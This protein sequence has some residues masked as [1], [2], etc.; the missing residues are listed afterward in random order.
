[1]L[2]YCTNI[3]KFRMDK[4]MSQQELADLAGYKSRSSI[5][6][7]EKGITMLSFRQ[8]RKI[9][10]IL[11]VELKDLIPEYEALKP[12]DPARTVEQ[13]KESLEKHREKQEEIFQDL[14]SRTDEVGIA[15]RRL[16]VAVLKEE[17]YKAMSQVDKDF[18]ISYRR[19]N[20]NNKQ[21]I[22]N[23]M[24]TMILQQNAPSDEGES[25]P[26]TQKG[27]PSLQQCLDVQK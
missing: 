11:G 19:L 17:R 10:E 27:T 22:M 18:L 14:Y 1:M 23:M 3:R 9:A 7:I 20:A 13:M 16:A 5:N 15:F 21:L 6:K 26:D 2:A 12:K 4:G 24:K 8:A 25:V